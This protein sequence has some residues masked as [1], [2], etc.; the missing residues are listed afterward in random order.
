MGLRNVHE[1][2]EGLILTLPSRQGPRM[3]SRKA[4]ATEH[5]ILGHPY[6]SV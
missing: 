2:P 5:L 3:L 4:F 6:S 1:Q